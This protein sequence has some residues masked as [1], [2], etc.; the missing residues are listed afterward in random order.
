MSAPA[1]RATIPMMTAASPERRLKDTGS[2]GGMT[3]VLDTNSP[4]GGAIEQ[5]RRLDRCGADGKVAA[6]CGDGGS[7]VVRWYSGRSVGVPADAAQ[8]T[9]EPA[10]SSVTL[11]RQRREMSPR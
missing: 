1:N 4:L 9:T 8:G 11:T 7:G 3:M 6:V 2:R 10:G 5:R